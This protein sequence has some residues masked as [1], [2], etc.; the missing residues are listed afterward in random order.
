MC[1]DHIKRISDQS[2][3]TDGNYQHLINASN[4]LSDTQDLITKCT[5]LSGVIFGI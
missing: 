1:S 5:I 4:F 3:D 2:G